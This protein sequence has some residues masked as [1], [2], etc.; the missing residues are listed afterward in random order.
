MPRPGMDATG[1]RST[2]KIIFSFGS[3]ITSVESEWLRPTYFSSS[4]VPP[5]VM[6]RPLSLTVSSG[7][8]VCGI[9]QHGKPLFGAL[10][11]D[12]PGAGVLE[13][14]AAGNVVV[15]MVAVDQIL[16]RLAGDLLD[17]VD[18]GLA[19]GRPAVGD[20]IGRDHARLGD[21]EHGLVVAVAEDVDVVRALHFGRGKGRRRWRLRQTWADV[22]WRQQRLR[23]R[24]RLFA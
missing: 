5:S 18:V 13:R 23:L 20:W 1:I 15:V 3:R 14:L 7:I 6:V 21:D 24:R 2:T 19:A 16:D 4:V 22:R 9:F 11:R 10:V 12:H 8:T 17:L